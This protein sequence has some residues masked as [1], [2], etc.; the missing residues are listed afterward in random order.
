VN[1]NTSLSLTLARAIRLD[2]ASRLALVGA[3]GKSTALFCLARS[4]TPPVVLTATSHLAL[5]QTLQADRH[6]LIASLADIPSVS[7]IEGNILLF[8]GVEE[9]ERTLGL[10]Q[11]A[12]E[13]L[14]SLA[15]ERTLP[16]LIEADGSRQLPLKAPAPHEPP[17]PS[18]V[19]VVVVVAGL[20]GLGKSLDEKTVHRSDIFA[21][22]SG[23]PPG[24]VITPEGLV[25]VL[26][27]PE[28]GL[29]NIPPGA[30][31]IALLNQLDDPDLLKKGKHLA[32]ML[33]PQY[34][35]V[36]LASLGD[37][38][39]DN[40]NQG[41]ERIYWVRERTAGIVLAA[42]SASRFGR[43]K[44]LL[45][46][47]GEALVRRSAQAALQAGLRPVVVVTGAYHQ[48]VQETLAGLDV[49]IVHNLR[50][51]EGQST[52]VKTGLLALPANI[53]AAVFLLADQPHVTPQLIEALY[54][55]HSVTLSPVTAP[56]VSGRRVSPVLFD[57]D[58]FVSLLS[59]TGDVGGRGIFATLDP[60]EITLVPWDD[61]ALLLDIDT[62]EDYQRMIDADSGQ[63]NDNL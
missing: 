18:F 7:D 16:L 22:L 10:E 51:E 25:R 48:E 30:R 26:S 61:P 2:L 3:G 41:G 34:D 56:L 13:S 4:L 37:P 9:G 57:R 12:L 14:L 33:L 20:Q 32:S 60:Q 55:S 27:S 8:T 58:T 49:V 31:R 19:D 6:F 38:S 44:Q 62:P 23:I 40:A 45:L 29:K 15:D 54:D 35:A 43:P 59:L 46:W 21:R 47:N 28:G 52:S 63:S 1:N 17:I 11:E 39:P 5:S 24:S 50:W 42:G 53:G 36:V